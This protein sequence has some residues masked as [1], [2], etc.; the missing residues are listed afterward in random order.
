[1]TQLND[2]SFYVTLSSSKTQEFSDNSPSR[3]Q[4]RLPQPLWLPDKWKVGVASVFLPG[5]PN[6]IP[7]V[8]TSHVSSSTTVHHETKP[9]KPFRIR[10]V[11]HL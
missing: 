11:A 10:S 5:T 9:T 2:S 4:Y 6:P 1:M 3:F 8:V 7:H